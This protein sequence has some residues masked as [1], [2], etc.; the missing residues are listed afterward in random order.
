[1]LIRRLFRRKPKFERYE[2]STTLSSPS[3]PPNSPPSPPS[4][5]EGQE[6][7]GEAPDTIKKGDN[8]DKVEEK[9]LSETEYKHPYGLR[10]DLPD[11]NVLIFKMRREIRRGNG[12]ALP[13]AFI[14]FDTQEAAVAAQ[15][16][17]VHHRPLQM[18]PPLL[19]I[20]PEDV[21]W[22]VLRMKW[23]ERIIR[24]LLV[25]CLI[26]AAI[27]FWSIPS[28]F[29]SIVSSID[30]L[31]K[32]VFLKWVGE[33]PSFIKGLIG[34]CAAQAGIPSLVVGEL[35]TQ[36][37]YFAFQVVQVFLITTLTSAASGA[38]ESILE[39]PLSAQ[40][41]LAENLPKASNFYL[42][43]I[44]IQCLAIGATGLLQMWSVLRHSV[45][46]KMSDN[47]RYNL[48][49]V[50]DTSMDS[51]GLFYPRALQHLIV[52][53]YLAE[54][55]L[56]MAIEEEIQEEERAKA[57]KAK[58]AAGHDD[59]AG[60]AASYYDIEEAFGDEEIEIEDLE[61]EEEE[62]IVGG[63]R[64][65]EGAASVR[66]AIVEWIKSWIM[67]KV[68]L[69][70]RKGGLMAA[71]KEMKA[72][73]R[74]TRKHHED[75]KP[76]GEEKPPNFLAKWLHPEEHED[77]VALRKLLPKDDHRDISYPEKNNYCTYQPPELWKPKPTLWI[78][79]DDARV[80]RQEVAHT[81]LSIPITDRGATLNAGGLIKADLDAAPFVE[82]QF[83]L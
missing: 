32:V 52:G 44:L 4:G 22:E 66:A 20:R 12:E 27:I 78:P 30:T 31:T 39:Q 49:Y 18:A 51:K 11:L 35:F 45:V 72:W 74:K 26:S 16:V 23:W 14:E 1:M 6:S 83:L 24:R 73:T 21:V 69:D 71:L 54:I 15:Q 2:D 68:K 56:T 5:L 43:Y 40:K 13:A 67:A 41:L 10:P 36:N 62:H 55:C 33:L 9:D 70:E 46:A 38:L 53:L 17:V 42:S 63:T 50:F 65:I 19:Y 8:T 48:I 58:A 25:M 59:S 80:S 75:D 47:P 61:E 81:S 29:I 7:P 82:P 60:A 77:F 79:R 64:A 3:S 76:D 57:A 28:A 34:V 37:A